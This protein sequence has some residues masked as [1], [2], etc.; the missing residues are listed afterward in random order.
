[1]SW[2]RLE[3]FVR[4]EDDQLPPEGLGLDWVVQFFSGEL[5]AI[6]IDDPS[7]VSAE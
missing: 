1:M 3:M 7:L 2:Y 6:E 4:L 5:S